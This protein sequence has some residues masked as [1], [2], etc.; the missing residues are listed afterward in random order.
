MSRVT[1]KTDENSFSN[2]VIKFSV[3]EYTKARE[4]VITL[5]CCC[6]SM[7]VQTNSIVS[8]IIHW[9]LVQV[10]YFSNNDNLLRVFLNQNLYL[11][12]IFCI[13]PSFVVYNIYLKELDI[14]KYLQI[15]SYSF[16]LRAEGGL[17]QIKM[18]MVTWHAYGI[19]FRYCIKIFSLTIS[20][21][22]NL[23]GC[24]LTISCKFRHV[25]AA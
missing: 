22:K 20:A 17:Y 15:F 4:A 11:Y 12:V 14:R 23:S 6:D 3:R 18:K 5:A 21:T 16:N 9:I 25:K 2:K 8:Q 19:S 13:W 1:I 10:T 24:S 7:T